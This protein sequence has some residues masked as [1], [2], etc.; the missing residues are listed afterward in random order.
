[1]FSYLSTVLFAGTPPAAMV[2]G[3]F[4][5]GAFCEKLGRDGELISIIRPCVDC[6]LLTGNWCEAS[7]FAENWL[8]SKLEDWQ[9]SQITPHCTFCEK[10]IM[11]GL[12]Q[13]FTHLSIDLDHHFM[14]N[15]PRNEIHIGH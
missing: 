6:G 5:V 1:M 7:C 2:K 13:N 14:F 12:C 15:L 9:D 4:V 8:G 3:D 11:S 10:N